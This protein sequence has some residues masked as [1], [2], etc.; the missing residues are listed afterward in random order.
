[1]AKKARE[2]INKNIETVQNIA[3][4]L[5]EHMVDVETLLSSIA[6]DYSSEDEKK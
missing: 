4:L 2:V 1:M 5:G 3:S 6:E